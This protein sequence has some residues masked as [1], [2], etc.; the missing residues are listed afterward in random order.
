MTYAEG[1]RVGLPSVR[2]TAHSR[3]GEQCRNWAKVGS[4]VCR[5]HGGHL[6]QVVRK[7]DE[8]LTFAQLLQSDPRPVGEVLLDALHNADVAMQDMRVRLVEGGEPVTVD[9]LDR[10]IT[11]SRLTHHLAKTTVDAGVEVQLVN[12]QRANV[13]EVGGFL[14]DTLLTVLNAL[15]LHPAW[16]SY[17]L[18]LASY[19][20]LEVAHQEGTRLFDRPSE[21]LPPEPVP[22]REP[23]LLPDPRA[24]P[25]PFRS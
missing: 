3:S 25:S 20:F 4:T 24:I 1:R 22:P 23:I 12:Q 11:L 10:F 6:P 7:R 21:S 17:L 19:R 14:A 16:R 5:M 18:D 2:C 8:R 9:Q 13:E 15:P